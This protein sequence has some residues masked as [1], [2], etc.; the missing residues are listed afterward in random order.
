MIIIHLM[1]A[2]NR[3]AQQYDIK[4]NKRRKNGI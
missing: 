2:I 3:K 4:T 1:T